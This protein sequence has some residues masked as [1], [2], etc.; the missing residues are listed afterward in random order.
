MPMDQ[1]TIN[2][3]NFSV[4]SP[5]GGR[6]GTITYDPLSKTA[7]FTPDALFQPGETIDVN[8]SQ[9]VSN[10]WG[11]QMGLDLDWTFEITTATN[12]QT[13]DPGVLPGVFAL[14]QNYPNPFN[15][16][17]QI[18]FSLAAPGPVGLRVYNMLGQLVK[19]LVNGDLPA[20][21]HRALWDGSDQ[22]G[23][24]LGSGVYFYRLEAEG[25]ADVRRM[26]LVR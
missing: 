19:T 26:V 6:S 21:Q 5:G 14:H 15:A 4:S 17:T 12:V 13:P 18:R 3:D 10:L 16:E 23:S 2:S 8:I 25:Q 20:G 1:E 11:M 22:N 7:T 24:A 9:H